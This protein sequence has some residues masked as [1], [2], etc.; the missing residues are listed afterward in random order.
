MLVPQNASFGL[1]KNSSTASVTSAG[2]I[3]PYDYVITNIGNVTLTNV[4]LTDNNT[5]NTPVCVPAQP[6]TLI[7]AAI[8]NCIAQHTVTLAE[9]N[10]GGNLSNTA[11]ADSDQTGSVQESL[12]IPIT[13]LFDPPFGIKDFDESGVPVLRWTMVWI[14]D[15]NAV[16]LDSEVY[17]PIPVGT[18]Y[19][20]SGPASGYG[21]PGGAPLLSTDIGVSCTTEA[22]SVTTTTLC[23]YEGPTGPN[24]LGQ[25]VWS[26]TLGPDPGATNAG[27]ASNE[28]VITFRVTVDAGITTAENTATID[29]DLNDDGIINEADGETEVAS[30]QAVWVETPLPR[31]PETGFAPGVVTSIPDQSA[32]Y[33]YQPLGNT[34]IE[35]PALA[36]RTSI[37]GIPIVED[38]WD[39]TWLSGQ[40]GW[41]QGTAFPSFSGNSVITGHVYLPSG[42]QG[43]FIN[44][45]QLS[46]DDKIIVHAFGTQYIYQVRSNKV[47]KPD[48]PGILRHEEYSWLT[49]VT[50]KGYNE[51]TDSYNY[52]VVVRAVLVDIKQDWYH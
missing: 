28:I 14:N 6:A 40:A 22:G 3:V 30:A 46:W 7:P 47:V 51:W 49:L 1:T 48:D 36:V 39:V 25:I 5:D 34:W 45:S 19:L 8:I 41:L 52:R 13:R 24:P 20:A 9:F 12:D 15:S 21:I 18:T 11:T 50:C 16:A 4:T 2:E 10:A 33:T 44:L 23:Y 27:N 37:V 42:I 31:T 29:A 38:E 32:E 26:G 43:P 35:V 17:D